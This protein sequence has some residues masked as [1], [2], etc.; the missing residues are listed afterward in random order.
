MAG[1]TALELAVLVGLPGAGK[2]SF[3]RTHLAGDHVH[4]SKDLMR[5]ARRRGERQLVQIE[6]ALRSGR[7][8][9]VDNTNP[10]VSDRS[11]LIAA[12]RAHGARVVGYYVDTAA[13]D[14]AARNRARE[15][16]E[17]VPDVAI[18]VAARRLERPARS[19]GFDAVF[20]VRVADGGFEVTEE[21]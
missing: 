4:V 9:A 11:P 17:R 16:R 12:G 3:F 5:E 6:A 2:T 19:E 7:S 15:G 13:R 10:R 14:C 1:G 21:P 20:R 8:V 18:Y